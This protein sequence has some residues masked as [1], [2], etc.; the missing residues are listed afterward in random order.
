MAEDLIIMTRVFELLEWL[1][2][3]AERFPRAQRFLLTQ[4]IMNACLDLQ[5]QLIEA[6]GAR[7]RDRASTLRRADDRLQTL[8]VYLRLIHRWQWLSDSQYHHVSE[9]VAEIGRLL[10]GWRR[11]AEG[12]KR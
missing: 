9:R 8:R 4:R 6:R 7:G 3:K 5:E 12:A 2:P 10:G 1:L 11:Q